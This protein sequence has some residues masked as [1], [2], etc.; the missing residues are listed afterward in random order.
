MS[1][2]LTYNLLVQNI[3][4]YMQRNDQQLLNAIPSIILFAQRRIA[5]DLK[6][7]VTEQYFD[8]VLTPG[9]NKLNKPGNWLNTMYFTLYRGAGFTEKKP[10]LIR[11]LEFCNKY[12]PKSNVMGEPLYYADY[13]YDYWTVAPTP[14]LAYPVTIAMLG[15]PA[16]I[17]E[18]NQVNEIT[19]RMPDLLQ[20]A[21]LYESNL[22]AKN[23]E[24]A[25]FYQARYGEAL[26]PAIQEDKAR[27]TDRFTD[28]SKD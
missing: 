21:A 11:S 2:V 25:N 13:G 3:L 4:S 8:G 20:F 5:R 24:Q 14:D 1:A 10:I 19:I 12:S 27:T 16:P 17:D 28:R 26:A 6:T 23:Y 9:I 22:W 18:V 7:L 15:I